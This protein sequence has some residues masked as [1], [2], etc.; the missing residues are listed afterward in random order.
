M[1]VE[2]LPKDE[3]NERLVD[4][5]HPAEWEN[6]EPSNP[7]NLVVVG[8]GT[9]GL[10][11]AA[12]AAGLGAR[13]ALIER[14]LMGGDC[15]NFGCVP[16]K[17]LIR[18]ATAVADIRGS[19]RFGARV[20]GEVTVDFAEAMQWMRRQRAAISSNDSAHRFR[21]LGVDVFLGSARFT[22]PRTVEVD[23]CELRFAKAVVATG[24]RAVAPPIP[25]LADAGY[26][27]NETVFELTARPERI[28]VIGAGPIGCE[29]SQSFARM[30]SRVWLLEM[31][32]RVLGKDDADA[33]A[34]VQEA[35]TRDGVE[36]VLGASIEGVG[37]AGDTTTLTYTSGGERSEIEV[38]AVLVSAG[39]R[40]NVED[41]GLEAA[42]VDF[43]ARK[44]VIVDD[45]LRTSNPRIFAAGD[46]ASRYQFTHA[47]DFLAR[48]V[49]A[50]ALFPGRQKASALTIPWATYTDPQVA[51]VGLTPEAAAQQGV[52]I[53]TFSH[54]LE[55]TD[56]AIVDGETDGFV[57]IHVHRG[58]DR[59]AGATIVARHAGDM[60]GEVTMA[61]V[62]GIGLG[63]IAKVIH[64]YPTQAEAIRRV[65]DAY[66][67]TRLTPGVKK[68]MGWWLGW[69]R[70]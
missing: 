12:G 60:I 66:N 35:L 7:Y 18:S 13:V 37:R 42:G 25:G 8:A 52:D 69:T 63:G 16:S 14:H 61:M 36:T 17:A 4:N 57:K 23:G 20:N 45:R 10:V 29:L 5:V 21:G 24:G 40:P 43:D 70:G 44:G 49:L 62:H 48:I 9:A 39:R 1:A 22:G 58:S 55:D 28:A 6:P 15:L 67:R 30:G 11:S 68:L 34:I 2:I 53:E 50:N 33:S 26:L 51:H 27:T 65:G 38:D 41:M 46:V 47:A 32:D 19:A 54:P 59:I 64:P 3:H 31:A 56:R